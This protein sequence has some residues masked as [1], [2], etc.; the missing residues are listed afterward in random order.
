[1]GT[2]FHLVKSR[3]MRFDVGQQNAAEFGKV[4]AT[5]FDLEHPDAEMF[6]EPGNGIAD[7]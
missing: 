6:L 4:C 3:Q 1:M 7:R 5:A 2:V